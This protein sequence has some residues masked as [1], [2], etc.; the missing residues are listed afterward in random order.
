MDVDI[1][2]FI[3]L[4]CGGEGERRADSVG[5]RS[6]SGSTGMARYGDVCLHPFHHQYL[7]REG[8]GLWR[9]EAGAVQSFRFQC[10]RNCKDAGG[11]RV[12]GGGADL[13]A[14]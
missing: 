3:H 6:F 9:R 4:G 5:S 2:G 1:V 12:Q 7:Y 8:M 14:P 11:R 10:G 13:Q